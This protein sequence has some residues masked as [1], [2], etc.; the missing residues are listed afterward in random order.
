[1]TAR[2]STTWLILLF[3]GLGTFLPAPSESSRRNKSLALEV[4]T[5]RDILALNPEMARFLVERIGYKQV[6]YARLQALLDA[7]FGKK[8]L[9][10]TYGN[11]RT[12][13][14]IETFETQSGNCL[15]FT[16][17]FVAMARHLGLDAYFQE[18]TEVMS[19][20]Q[21]G[22]LMISNK[23]MFAEVEIDNGVTRVDFL[24]GEQ[25]RY[26]KTRRISDRRAL[27]H[28][29][30]NIGAEKL[31]D[32]ETE[33]AVEL[34]EKAIAADDSF[35]PALVNLGVAQRR[36]GA[37]DLAEQ[38]F[39]AALEVDAAEHAAASNLAGLYLS[40][41]READ[42]APLLRRV[43]DYLLQNP[44]HH[45]RLGLQTAEAGKPH[46]AIRH[47]KEAIRRMPRDSE[48]HVTL[49]DLYLE[50]DDTANA[51][52]TLEKA[53]RLTDDE[54]RKSELNRRLEGLDVG[55]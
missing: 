11:T 53:V 32:G 16:L 3:F 10:I 45:F 51:V 40:R 37:F 29:F 42:A 12:K 4:E 7:I 13:T 17:L 47:V 52:E 23:H 27:A 38:S 31:T 21:K 18:V 50:V 55:I 35:S 25:K 14:A 48:F 39:L 24:R 44:F 33:L 19:W 43:D 6:R 20:D 15:S 5:E 1:M 8:G 46:D 30:N 22:E 34:F 49:A 2:S 54:S 26:R 41:G 9:D 36:A 28:F